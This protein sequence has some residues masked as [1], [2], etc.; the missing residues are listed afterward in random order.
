MRG[1]IELPDIHNVVLVLQNGSLVVVDIEIVGG[2][3]DGHD[4]GET[5]GSRLPVHS[6]AGIL[7]LVSSDNREQVV[8]FEESASGG[9]GEKVRAASDMVV[10]EVIA[11]LFLAKVLK[12]VSPED[13]A[14][15]PLGRR[16]PESVNLVVMVS[17]NGKG[18][19]SQSSQ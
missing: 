1:A 5:S 14:H 6:V 7:G 9:V 17:Y 2:R 10:Q 19:S 11:G 18:V 16:L 8:L 12:R 15:E 3:E 4:T 13:V